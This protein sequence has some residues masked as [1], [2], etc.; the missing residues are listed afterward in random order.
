MTHRRAQ[1]D[2]TR[3]TDAP[4]C[5]DALLDPEQ[6]PLMGRYELLTRVAS[7]GMATVWAARLR[8]SRGF[9]KIVALK[10][11]LPRLSE[12]PKY[13]RMFL[14]E[15]ACASRIHH[16][17]VAQILDLGDDNG[18]LFLAMEWV[19]G[20]TIDELLSR[21]RTLG[22]EIPLP[23][24]IRIAIQVASGL[25][26][27]HE[28]RGA[29]GE[30]VGLVHGD[31]SPQ[32]II[33][34]FDGVTKLVDFGIAKMT[35]ALPDG[36]TRSKQV[37]GKAAYLAPEQINGAAID[38][39]ID[40]FSLGLVLHLLTTG[41][42][43]FQGGSPTATL[44][45]IGG[46]SEAAPPGA[47]FADFPGELSSTIAQC[48][49]KDPERRWKTSDELVWALESSISSDLRATD[50]DVAM[51]V[52]AV[53]GDLR[54]QRWGALSASNTTPP[55]PSA[56]APR[57]A[58]AEDTRVEFRPLGHRPRTQGSRGPRG[59]KRAVALLAVLS[60]L[61]AALAAG[62]GLLAMA[63]EAPPSTSARP[64]VDRAPPA[65]VRVRREP[66]PAEPSPRKKA[67]AKPR[68]TPSHRHRVTR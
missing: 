57:D 45:K 53:A 16:P 36:T 30:L 59:M 62:S 48:L 10:T 66:P 39:R 9:Q 55:P 31:V 12:N 51:L 68:P 41:T 15:A 26:A 67:E 33:V 6:G 46:P 35:E 38:R 20:I 3:G 5:E 19:D 52:R 23:V 40:V 1:R 43:P 11:I 13:E 61:L 65:D 50:Q 21:A 24:A 29:D 14:A 18:V 64:P 58:S 37:W 25:H 27:A 49:A 2:G 54:V 63:E 47:A 7:G 8:G 44:C 60:A 17:N 22:I 28:L 34:S 56:P 32:N 4:V 42:H